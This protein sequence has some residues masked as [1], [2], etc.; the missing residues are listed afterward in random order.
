MWFWNRGKIWVETLAL[1]LLSLVMRT[2]HFRDSVPSP[3]TGSG[4]CTLPSRGPS[5]WEGPGTALGWREI[6]C[7]VIGGCFVIVPELGTQG[8]IINKGWSEAGVF[9]EICQKI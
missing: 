9:P 1:P 4:N 7:P 2:Y 5:V 6:R 3:K 8:G